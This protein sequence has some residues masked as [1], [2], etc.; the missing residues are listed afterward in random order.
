MGAVCISDGKQ[1][2]AGWE[3]D[4]IKFAYRYWCRNQNERHP[5]DGP[6]L[7]KELKK[8]M[9]EMGRARPTDAKSGK[10]CW[11]TTVPS[12]DHARLSFE[13]AMN[14]EGQIEWDPE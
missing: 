5:V 11:H 1:W 3:R 7:F 6:V 14:A 4:I 9:P 2:E 8:L 13:K 12:L 10:R